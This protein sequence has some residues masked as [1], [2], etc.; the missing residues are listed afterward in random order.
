MLYKVIIKDHL[1]NVFPGRTVEIEAGS[2]MDAH[3][4]VYFSHLTEDESI[5]EI[6]DEDSNVVYES[7]DGFADTELF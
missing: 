3:K 2:A 7:Q 4:D 5:V 6:R 1:L